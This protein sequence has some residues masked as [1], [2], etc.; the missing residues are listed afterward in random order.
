MTLDRTPETPL[1]SQHPL[2]VT[3]AWLADRIDRPDF[4]LI[5]CGEPV[6][7]QRV[8]IPGAVS[9]SHQPYLKGKDDPLLVMGPEEF[10]QLVRPLGVSND[11]A[12]I[13]YDD[14]A[15]LYAAR[16]WWVFD[17]FGHHDV[18]VLDGGLNAW[19]DEA[20]PLTSERPHPAPGNV[21]AR[22]DDSHLCR[23]DDLRE[24]VDAGDVQIWDTRS[25][26]EWTGTNARG[27][28]R[29]GHVPGAKHLEWSDLMEGP[30]ARRFRPLAEIRRTLVEAGINPEATTV[31]Y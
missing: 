18:R 20:R 30:P 3:T 19:L 1:Q 21:T 23:V 8:H 13:L 15:S 17:H 12:V 5:D 22:V 10:E 31:T 4:V 28:K 6:A 7:Y 11:S 29:V 2:L 25:D 27:N 24:L 16:I 26:G 14:N 9:I